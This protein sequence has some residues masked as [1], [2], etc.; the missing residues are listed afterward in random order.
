MGG[1]E[2]VGGNILGY[3][4]ALS[5]PGVWRDSLSLSGFPGS[6]Q[7]CGGRVVPGCP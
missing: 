4:P 2:Y 6:V 1:E 5:I 7:D 3:Q